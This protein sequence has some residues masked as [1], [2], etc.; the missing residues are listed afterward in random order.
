MAIAR[1]CSRLNCWHG[2]F[3]NLPPPRII[4]WCL[5][6]EFRL[7]A[8][9]LRRVSPPGEQRSAPRTTFIPL[10]KPPMNC[11]RPAWI[12]S[13]L[14][15]A[16]NRGLNAIRGPGLF[17]W[18]LKSTLGRG[19][20]PCMPGTARAF[21]PPIILAGAPDCHAECMRARSPPCRSGFGRMEATPGVHITKGDA[22]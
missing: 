12:I 19:V 8:E 2:W 22:M 1:S 15:G 13:R 4:E 20:F 18:R 21:Y 7:P 5:V 14:R 3:S 17:S 9:P 16:N 10:F 11:E 6:G